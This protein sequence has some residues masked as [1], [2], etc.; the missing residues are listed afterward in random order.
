MEEVDDLN[1]ELNNL[2]DFQ[3]NSSGANDKVKRVN[4]QSESS[5]S[6]SSIDQ[7][8]PRNIDQLIPMSV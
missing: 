3:S 1:N 7:N 6:G 8:S 5:S 4:R 2:L